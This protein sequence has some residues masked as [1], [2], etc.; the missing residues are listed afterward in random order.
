MLV[1]KSV[2]AGDNGFFSYRVNVSGFAFGLAV[3][4]DLE[5]VVGAI[6]LPL[7]VGVHGWMG[8]VWLG[9]SPMLWRRAS[10]L[11]SFSWVGVCLAMML[12][13]SVL[14]GS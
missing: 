14:S 10:Q 9:L 4:D 7:A 8:V 1:V 12:C 13:M 2:V 5:V 3:G 6:G 11:S